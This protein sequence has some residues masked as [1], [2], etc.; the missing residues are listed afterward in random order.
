MEFF[1]LDEIVENITKREWGG[2][3]H[4]K[5]K[6]SGL[7]FGELRSAST[8]HGRVVTTYLAWQIMPVLQCEGRRK[9]T[10][11]TFNHIVFLFT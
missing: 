9:P 8:Q 2:S 1:S 7:L 5:E 4:N 6:F 3:G 11:T 10:V